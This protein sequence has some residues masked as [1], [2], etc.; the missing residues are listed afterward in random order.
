MKVQFARR[1]TQDFLGAPGSV[2]RVAHGPE[3][4]T[5]PFRRGEVEEAPGY[6]DRRSSK[7]TRK[8]KDIGIQSDIRR[9][10]RLEDP[11]DQYQ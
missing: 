11:H 3:H 4:P 6:T 2:R 10:F 7:R 5:L 1:S 8:T 9:C